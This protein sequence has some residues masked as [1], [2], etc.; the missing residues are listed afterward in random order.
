MWHFS[1]FLLYYL[2]I[3]KTLFIFAADLINGKYSR[4]NNINTYGLLI[5]IIGIL[6]Q[7]AS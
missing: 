2:Q 4:M 7:E 6:L 5:A 3:P 1:T